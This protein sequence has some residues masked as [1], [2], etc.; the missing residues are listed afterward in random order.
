MGASGRGRRRGPDRVPGEPERTDRP[1]EQ[2]RP[3][4]D[5]DPA[6]GDHRPAP[7]VALRQPHRDADGAPR[8]LDLV[9]QP[10]LQP[11]AREGADR[12]VHEPAGRPVRPGEPVLVDHPSGD[13]KRRGRAD[14]R[15]ARARPQRLRPLHDDGR[16][17]ALAGAL[18]ARVRRRHAEAVP[19]AGRP[20]ERVLA[21]LKP[22]HLSHRPR[23]PAV[24]PA[25]RHDHAGQPAAGAGGKRA[26]RVLAGRARR[27][28][29]HLFQQA[30]RRDAQA[31]EV[32]RPRRP[33]AAQLD[34]GRSHRRPHTSPARP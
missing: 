27:L 10:G 18:V 7:G 16:L 20:E 2:P 5:H 15:P 13:R 23:V 30:L 25:A 21:A 26:A 24:R 14:R 4:D 6:A 8:G 28:R 19:Q 29:G 3:A 32:R 1:C 9:R 22:A 33:V 34:A 17:A 31:R 12:A 11:P